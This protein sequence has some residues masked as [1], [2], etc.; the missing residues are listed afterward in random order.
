LL[1]T[2]F[3]DDPEAVHYLLN[4]VTEVQLEVYYAL[5]NA[6]GGIEH[7]TSIDFD[8]VREKYKSFVSDDICATSGLICSV[9]SAFLTIMT[10]AVG[11]GDA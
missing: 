6:V 4:M 7:M 2:G 1:Y 5:V 3:Y 9:S 10:V 8:P 11:S